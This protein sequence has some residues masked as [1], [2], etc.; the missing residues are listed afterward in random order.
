MDFFEKPIG[1]TDFLK[2][3]HEILGTV[4]ENGKK[5]LEAVRTTESYGNKKGQPPIQNKI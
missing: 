5:S 2:R 4:P 3:V 1:I